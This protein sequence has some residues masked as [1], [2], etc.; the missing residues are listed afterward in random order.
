MYASVDPQ[1]RLRTKVVL[2]G[3]F[4]EGLIKTRRVFF[5][6]KI[7]F[8]GATHFDPAFQLLDVEIYISFVP[9]ARHATIF[10]R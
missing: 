10:G 8:A 7:P 6:F 2:K 1:I 3:L 4:C 5:F 9:F